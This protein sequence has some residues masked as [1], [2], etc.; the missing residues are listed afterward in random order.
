MRFLTIGVCLCVLAF[1]TN[2]VWHLPSNIISRS[3]FLFLMAQLL[4][5]ALGMCANWRAG[6]SSLLYY[7]IFYFTFVL[8][9]LAAINLTIQFLRLFPSAQVAG[10]FALTAFLFISCLSSV[11]MLGL[12]RANM[13][14]WYSTAHVACACI[15]LLCGVLTLSSLVF[16]AD[17][18]TDC[19]RFFLGLL[20]TL[21]GIYQCAE[22]SLYLR[23]RSDLVSYFSISPTVIALLMFLFLSVSLSQQKELSRQPQRDIARIDASTAVALG[24]MR[25]AREHK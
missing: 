17:H 15:F 4:F 9:A 18:A 20:W 16:Q 22:A 7:K 10:T 24:T 1:L 11:F 8:V 12:R 2:Q 23:A 14:A 25:V 13:L 5:S 21:T 6:I 19:I 3:T